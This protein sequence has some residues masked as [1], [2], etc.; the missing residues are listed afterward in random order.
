MPETEFEN[1][2]IYAVIGGNGSGKTTFARL[3][4]GIEKDDSGKTALPKGIKTGYMPQ[5]S[6]AFRMSVARNLTL[7]GKDAE[8]RERLL[9]AL[10]IDTLAGQSAKR[11]SGGETAR[12]ALA[13]LL[14]RDYELLILDEPTAAMDVEST[15]AAE[16]LLSD[17]CRDTGAGIL[18]VTHSLQQARRIA[19][20][21]LFLHQGE[22]RE[23]GVASRLLSAPETEELRRFLEF[24]G[25]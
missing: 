20:H 3:M 18:L 19:Q 6:Y 22:L 15:L 12:M 24:Y 8:R 16:T 17:Y 25:I 5:K 9:R 14:M 13:R 4:A 11:L 7:N 1:G 10:Q 23:Q 21:V 2:K